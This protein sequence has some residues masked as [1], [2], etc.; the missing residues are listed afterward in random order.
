MI[1]PFLGPRAKSIRTGKLNF[2][3]QQY[4]WPWFAQIHVSAAAGT[5]TGHLKV[6]TGYTLNT[7]SILAYHHGL[8]LGALCLLLRLY[9]YG[10]FEISLTPVFLGQPSLSVVGWWLFI[11]VCQ[12]AP[13]SMMQELYPYQ[14]F[15]HAWAIKWLNLW[16]MMCMLCLKKGF[17]ADLRMPVSKNTTC[18]MVHAVTQHHT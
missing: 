6:D 10:G 9:G 16:S 8:S 13:S 5:F 2:I 4:D 11:G 7:W 3:Q 1:S 15:K 18:T 17:Q 14:T 12:A